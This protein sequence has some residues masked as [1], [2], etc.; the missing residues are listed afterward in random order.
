MQPLQKSGSGIE[1]Q[2]EQQA[3]DLELTYV[4][5]KQLANNRRLPRNSYHTRLTRIHYLGSV[6]PYQSSIHS[7]ARHP[8][9]GTYTT[10]FIIT[11]TRLILFFYELYSS[12]GSTGPFHLS[13][14]RVPVALE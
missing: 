14:V 12:I 5:N 9:H 3:N 2:S 4:P 13:A 10:T 1:R 8:S 7:Q 11:S 6:F